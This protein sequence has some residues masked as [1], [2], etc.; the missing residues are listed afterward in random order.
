MEAIG[1]GGDENANK[2]LTVLRAIDK[3]DRLGADGVRLLLAGGRKDES[4]DFTK[5]AELDEH[6]IESLLNFL[7]PIR[8]YA[9]ENRQAPRPWDDMQQTSA[10]MSKI[11]LS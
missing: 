3:L 6:A 4:G 2:R 9:V 10:G 1:L 7:R 8:G 11:G 5:G